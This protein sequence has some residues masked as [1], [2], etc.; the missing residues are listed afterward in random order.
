VKRRLTL[1][2][3]PFMAIAGIFRE[4]KG[5]NHPSFTML[6]TEPGDDVKPFHNGNWWWCGQEI[7]R[8]GST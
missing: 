7:G 4:A 3:A 5:A 8:P 2:G 6:T 1:N